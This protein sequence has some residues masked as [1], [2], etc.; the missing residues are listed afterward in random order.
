MHLPNPHCF[1]L[2]PATVPANHKIMQSVVC[3]N[4]ISGSFQNQQKLFLK[5]KMWNLL[6]N[7][8]CFVLS[9]KAL[10]KKSV[11]FTD[12]LFKFALLLFTTCLAILN[13]CSLA[14]LVTI[15]QYIFFA[16][17][18]RPGYSNL[19]HQHWRMLPHLVPQA[20]CSNEFFCHV[21]FTC[22]RL[23]FSY[24]H[25]EFVIA[26]AHNLHR[27]THPVQ[28]SIMHPSAVG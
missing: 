7:L 10:L 15:M 26:D 1:C 8:Q 6:V 13:A 2:A 5:V 3:D 11:P 20:L 23:T 16:R 17:S 25:K 21:T 4:V 28:N 22:T 24:S 9:L 14:A 19:W 12:K 27:L 18:L